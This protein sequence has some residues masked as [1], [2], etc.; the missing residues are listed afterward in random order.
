M[1]SKT[2]PRLRSVLTMFLL[3]CMLFPMQAEG[4]VYISDNLKGDSITVFVAKGKDDAF[5]KTDKSVSIANGETLKYIKPLEKRYKA[6]EGQFVAEHNGAN[7]V[8]G[9]NS[10]RF[11]P[12]NESWVENTVQN[13]TQKMEHSSVGHF[14][15]TP[16]PFFFVFLFTA[17]GG[18]CL[19]TARKRAKAGKSYGKPMMLVPA[20]LLLAA[21]IELF[22]LLYAGGDA[23]WWCEPESVGYVKSVLYAFPVMMGIGLQILVGIH[24][25]RMLEDVTRTSLSWTSVI[26]G[27]GVSIPI[28]LILVIVLAFSGH[29]EGIM[30]DVV[31]A[32]S[33]LGALAIGFLYSFWKNKKRL[34]IKSGL[35]FTS[36]S[37]IYA[38]GVIFAVVLL[39]FMIFKLIIAL[40]V[41][42]VAFVG[43]VIGL[44]MAFGGSGSSGG[45]AWQNPDGTWSNGNG[46]NYKSMGEAAR[47]R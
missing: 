18:I 11:S 27:V 5:V 28:S 20:G 33:F 24:Y 13:M 21:V 39:A 34:G 16:V 9:A 46:R 36:F 47:R 17:V 45:A 44:G 26:I 22:S 23:A 10:V 30:P 14:F 4:Q 42:I 32:V 41:Y 6:D 19:L 2:N 1:V 3:F 43:A 37:F 25:K 31:F 40:L 7:Y 29:N 12:D 35:L 38:I 8:V 15:Y